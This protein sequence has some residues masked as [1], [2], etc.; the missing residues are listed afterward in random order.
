MRN[1]AGLSSFGEA[2]Q[3]IPHTVYYFRILIPSVSSPPFPLFGW[4]Y[5]VSVRY[6]QL[7]L[8]SRCLGCCVVYDEDRGHSGASPFSFHC[9]PHRNENMGGLISKPDV[10]DEPVKT[11]YASHRSGS[12]CLAL[13]S[14]LCVLV[15]PFIAGLLM[16]GF[17]EQWAV[18]LTK[19]VVKYQGTA[20]LRAQTQQG[21]EYLWASSDILQTQLAGD[22]RFIKPYISY[23]NDDQ[24]RDDKTD[25]ITFNIE[26]PLEA[27]D[28]ISTFEFLPEFS[29]SFEEDS[30][31]VEDE[32]FLYMLTAPLISVVA[33]PAHFNS[34]ELYGKLGFKQTTP[35]W[36]SPYVRYDRAYNKSHFA[37]IRDIED[38][39]S[40]GAI[41]AKYSKR[42][43]SVAFEDRVVSWDSA[44]GNTLSDTFRIKIEMRLT[45]LEVSHV[46]STAQTVKNAWVQYFCLAYVVYW[47]F[48][49]VRRIIVKN[50]LVDTIVVFDNLARR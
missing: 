49:H 15:I 3:L 35:L 22:S 5:R 7:G 46:P 10:Y 27:G 2:V 8:H 28:I 14:M 45:A 38:I 29:Y 48:Y 33:P 24:D 23:F 26:L 43:E 37:S 40:I 1:F 30:L 32:V 50:G 11:T 39:R 4:M 44:P 31:K 12:V 20:I 21:K 16:G 13:F 34:V 18:F 47:F 36:S 6:R 42:N 17:W 25:F 19:P 9:F 41:A